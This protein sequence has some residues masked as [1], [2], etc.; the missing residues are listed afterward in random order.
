MKYIR[1]CLFLVLLFAGC[2][3]NQYQSDVADNQ[4]YEKQIHKDPSAAYVGEWNAPFRRIAGFGRTRRSVRGGSHRFRDAPGGSSEGEGCADP[5]LVAP[6]VVLSVAQSVERNLLTTCQ[7]GCVVRS[8]PVSSGL[9]GNPP[10]GRT[11]S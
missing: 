4:Y 10:F 1:S 5:Y 2:T 6:I 11:V 3:F 8:L 9:I 7:S